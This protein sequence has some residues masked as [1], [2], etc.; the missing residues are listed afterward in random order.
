VVAITSAII[1]G[2]IVA[3]SASIELVDPERTSGADDIFGVRQHPLHHRPP[4]RTAGALGRD[5][6]GRRR[7]LAGQRQRGHGEH[8]DGIADEGQRPVAA[9]AVGDVAGDGPKGV[10]G[11]LADAR[12]DADDGGGRAELRKKRSGHAA[13]ALVREIR[14]EIH[15]ADEQ[16]ES[17]DGRGRAWCHRCLMS[18]PVRW[19]QRRVRLL[20]SPR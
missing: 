14:E 8:V 3:P 9:G 20:R 7:P 2:P 5:Q 16:D 6:H 10:A 4:D 17:E 1:A 12:N 15:D 13:P 19:R 18:K 11:K